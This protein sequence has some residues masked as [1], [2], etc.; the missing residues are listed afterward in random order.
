MQGLALADTFSSSDKEKGILIGADHYHDIVTGEVIKGSLGPV[1]TSSKLGWLLSGTI[2]SCE[3]ENV[4]SNV[5]TSFVIEVLPPRENG[6]NEVQ[7]I[8]DSLNQLWKHEASGLSA[9]D[10]DENTKK[11]PLDIQEKEGRY[12]VSLPWKE[13]FREPLDSDLEMC[14]S[15]LTSLY[16]GAAGSNNELL[17]QGRKERGLGA[18]PQKN[19]GTTPFRARETPIIC[20]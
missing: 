8:V 14:R 11:K 7:E 1:A 16:T 6:I 9:I 17:L 12:E 20:K 4:C 10:G 5:V 13:N 15:R 19:F 3:T 2:S 18:C